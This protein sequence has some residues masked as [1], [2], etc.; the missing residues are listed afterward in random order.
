MG[1]FGRNV[2]VTGDVHEPHTMRQAARVV[3]QWLN[4]RSGRAGLTY[5][6]C[7]VQRPRRLMPDQLFADFVCWGNANFIADFVCGARAQK[8]TPAK[9]PH[10]KIVLN[11]KDAHTNVGS[12]FCAHRSYIRACVRFLCTWSHIYICIAHARRHQTA[13]QQL[14][15]CQSGDLYRREKSGSCASIANSRDCR[16]FVC[17]LPL[18]ATARTHTASVLFACVHSRRHLACRR[19]R[20]CYFY[21]EYTHG[22]AVNRVRHNAATD[23][24]PIHRVIEANNMVVRLGC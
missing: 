24:R 9:R 2:K 17:S 16:F 14:D 11:T 7:S 22:T 13:T 15:Q 19:V 12:S 4:S 23:D 20:K 5:S 8:S 3:V 18:T 1:S 6:R 21:F 10:G